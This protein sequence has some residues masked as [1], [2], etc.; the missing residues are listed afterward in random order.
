MTH[1]AYLD[2]EA[3]R[4]PAVDGV[5]WAETFEGLILIITWECTRTIFLTYNASIHIK[6]EGLHNIRHRLRK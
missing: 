3:K 1:P 6:A 2:K 5:A 4:L